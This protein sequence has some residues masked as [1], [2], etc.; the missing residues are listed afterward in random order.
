MKEPTDKADDKDKEKGYS[1]I[2]YDFFRSLKLTI[3]LLI[4]LALVSIIGTIITQNASS[5][6]GAASTRCSI[7]SA[8]LICITP[9]GFS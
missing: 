6:T 4:L 7:F 3:F 9:G 1:T 8:S 5:V 2:L